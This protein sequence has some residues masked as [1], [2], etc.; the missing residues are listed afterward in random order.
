MPFAASDLDELDIT[1]LGAVRAWMKNAGARAIVNCA[2][3]N[4]VDRAESEWEEAFLVNGIGPKNLAIA[5][6]EQ[7]IPLVHFSSDYV[8]NG[9]KGSP[10][11]IAD[12]PDPLNRYGESKWLGER[13]VIS[14]THRFY[15]LRLSWVFGAGNVNFPKKVL[16]WA[17][18]RETLEVVDDEI[19]CPTYTVDLASATLDLLETGAFGLYHLTNAGHCSRYEWARIVLEHAGSKSAVRPVKGERFPTPA[20]RPRFSALDRFPLETILARL[21]PSWQ[22]ATARFVT[23]IGAKP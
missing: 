18:E 4:A 10:Y 22:D 1:D 19:S 8:F 20:R 14:H 21:P 17:R 7:R 2:A 13:M 9:K 23:E 6:E 3:F 11:T 16:Q 5:A 15:L 12:R